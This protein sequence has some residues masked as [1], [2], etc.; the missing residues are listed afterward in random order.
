MQKWQMDFP[1]YSIHNYDSV[2]GPIFTGRTNG[3]GKGG[4]QF[5]E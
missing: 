4:S 2:M 3:I 1:I 5:N